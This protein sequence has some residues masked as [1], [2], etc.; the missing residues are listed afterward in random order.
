T[1]RG[2]AIN[3]LRKDLIKK[4]KNTKLKIYTI[5][6]LADIAYSFTNIPKDI[7]K[8]DKIIGEV[9]DRTYEIIDYIYQ[10]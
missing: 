6:E 8:R 7:V 4:L 1:E 2:I 3:P 9:E 10:K 5:E